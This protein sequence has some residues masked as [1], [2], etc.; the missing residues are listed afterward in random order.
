M[1]KDVL[2]PQ[3]YDLDIL[4]TY[5]FD[6]VKYLSDPRYLRFD[7]KPVF[8]IYKIMDLPDPLRIIADWRNTWRKMGLGEVHIAA[9]RSFPNPTSVSIHD[10]GVDAFVDFPPHSIS[11]FMKPAILPT[12]PDFEGSIYRYQDVVEGDISRYEQEDSTS[13]HRGVMGAWDNTA[14]R[15]NKA[16]LTYGASPVTFRSWLRRSLVQD[17]AKHPGEERMTFINAWNEWAE[18]TY[19]E[20]DQRYGIG[21]LEAV[22]SVRKMSEEA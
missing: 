17:A 1:N 9:V 8:V 4:K 19:L 21:F 7:G 10:L 6:V 2:M 16:H 14:R 13:V 5:A 22:R 11:P 12:A 15:G 3:G 18:G 20:P